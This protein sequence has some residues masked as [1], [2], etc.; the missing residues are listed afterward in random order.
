MALSYTLAGVVTLLAP[1]SEPGRPR[2]TLPP[3][4]NPGITGG[5][6]AWLCGF[7]GLVA[8][9]LLIGRWAGRGDRRR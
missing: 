1:T 2:P 3:L 8:V 6:A 7:V 5:Q 9:C 4:H